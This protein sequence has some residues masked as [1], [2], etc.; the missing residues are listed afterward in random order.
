MI[1][2]RKKYTHALVCGCKTCYVDRASKKEVAHHA[3]ERVAGRAL[4]SLTRSPDTAHH[5]IMRCQDHSS[6]RKELLPHCLCQRVEIPLALQPLGKPICRHLFLFGRLRMAVLLAVADPLDLAGRCPT[7]RHG[8]RRVRNRAAPLVG[9]SNPLL[10]LLGNEGRAIRCDL[11][12]TAIGGHEGLCCRERGCCRFLLLPS[13][14]VHFCTPP[15]LFLVHF[16]LP[17]LWRWRPESANARSG[18]HD[19]PRAERDTFFDGDAIFFVRTP[20]QFFFRRRPSKKMNDSMFDTMEEEMNSVGAEEP[21]PPHRT[22]PSSGVSVNTHTRCQKNAHCPNKN[23]H[24]GRCPKARR[25]AQTQSTV[26]ETVQTV[27][28]SLPSTNV[29]PTDVQ[30]ATLNVQYVTSNVEAD[31]QTDLSW[32]DK[33][34]PIVGDTADASERQL[35]KEFLESLLDTRVEGG[36]RKHYCGGCGHS[37]RDAAR[38]DSCI[39]HMRSCK[40][41]KSAFAQDSDITS[42]DA[43][44]VVS[45]ARLDMMLM[46]ADQNAAL[47]AENEALRKSQR[48][49]GITINNT[50]INNTV[51]I[52]PFNEEP[53]LSEGAI[54]GLLADAKRSVPAYVK[55]KHFKDGSPNVRIVQYRTKPQKY[56]ARILVERLRTRTS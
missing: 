20:N 11:A 31:V 37:P 29:E 5:R 51:N 49:G 28:D 46:L 55:L 16:S 12:T 47:R 52:Y 30:S 39:V 27:E 22:S 56:T 42:F 54:R 13:F 40:A 23:G 34:R 38:R 32:C 15:S 53:T 44:K 50:I 43:L 17:I 35:T 19:G 14:L 48:G 10:N 3:L 6:R 4:I 7:V 24:R 45:K 8:A 18:I 2:Y 21:S 36:F 25:T 26:T 9:E 1:R 33:Y 41:I